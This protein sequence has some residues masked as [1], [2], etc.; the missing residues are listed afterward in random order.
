MIIATFISELR[1]FY[2]INVS[3]LELFYVL[4]YFHFD[5]LSPK[6]ETWP[7]FASWGQSGDLGAHTVAPKWKLNISLFIQLRFEDPR[8]FKL[9]EF[10]ISKLL[11]VL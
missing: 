6:F 8:G 4:G 1:G 10:V 7:K 2:L 9:I 3:V 5:I 11:L